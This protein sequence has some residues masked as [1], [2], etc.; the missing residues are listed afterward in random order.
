M[1]HQRI[2]WCYVAFLALRTGFSVVRPFFFTDQGSDDAAINSVDPLFLSVSPLLTP[3]F[4]EQGL[5]LVQPGNSTDETLDNADVLSV[6]SRQRL[7]AVIPNV[8]HKASNIHAGFFVHKT[9]EEARAWA[10]GR[11]LMASFNP[12]DGPGAGKEK[13]PLADEILAKLSAPDFIAFVKE[14]T[15]AFPTRSS[16]TSEGL[17]ASNW[18]AKRWK[19]YTNGVS[20]AEVTEVAIEGYTQNNVVLTL[21]GR[22]E[23]RILLGA[24]MDSTEGPVK[25]GADDNASGCSVVNAIAL[26]VLSTKLQPENTI[27]FVLYGAEETGITV[28]Y[29]VGSKQ[30]AAMFKADGKPL[31]AVMNFDTVGGKKKTAADIH[32]N[33]NNVDT[34]LTSWLKS[35][36]TM[37]FP[38][39][40]QVDLPQHPAYAQSDHSSWHKQGFSATMPGKPINMYGNIHKPTD[41][42]DSLDGDHILIIAR[43]AALFTV[44]MAMADMKPDIGA[45]PPPNS[46][47]RNFQRNEKFN[48]MGRMKRKVLLDLIRQILL[49]LI[50]QILLDLI[51]QILLGRMSQWQTK[52][53][54]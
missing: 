17:S 19:G 10:V 36:V 51:R 35:L 48:L 12:P 33:A 29:P 6:S 27:V 8:V 39:V 34:S 54:P 9:R 4:L 50:R 28:G 5:T 46:G 23:K 26:A 18:L 15:E 45:T 49:D 2:L 43:V 11:R 44:H 52:V 37:Y 1:L 13:L 30:L 14:F 47:D 21:T 40:T 22:N 20:W 42:W 31:L 3:L 38:D 16:K 32:W 24:H 41:T 53:L 7:Q 25:P